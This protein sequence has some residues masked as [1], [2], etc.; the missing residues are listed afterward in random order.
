MGNL[1]GLGDYRKTLEALNAASVETTIDR[2]GVVEANT[3]DATLKVLCADIRKT[4]TRDGR[5]YKGTR[6][7]M[8]K[9][10]EYCDAVIDKGMPQWEYIATRE[11]WKPP[12]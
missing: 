8:D 11:G 4:L 12:S 10:R 6:D 9:L 3:E 1:R 2:L 7:R 5:I